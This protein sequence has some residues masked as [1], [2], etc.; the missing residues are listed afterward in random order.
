MEPSA[1]ATSSMVMVTHNPTRRDGLAAGADLT[2]AGVLADTGGGSATVGAAGGRAG[3][4][5][6]VYWTVASGT[7]SALAPATVGGGVRPLPGSAAAPIGVSGAITRSR[8]SGY[9]RSGWN[10]PCL[11]RP[12]RMLAASPSNPSRYALRM[13]SVVPLTV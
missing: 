6:G 11:L 8:N 12:A 13:F 4:A 1:A 7:D 2:A 3:A 5:A 9:D 10:G